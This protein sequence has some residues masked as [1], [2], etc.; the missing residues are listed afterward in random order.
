MSD[1]SQTL[2]G[3]I[4]PVVGM[5]APGTP[6]GGL[7]P[8]LVVAGKYRLVRYLARGGMAEVW[9]ATHEELRS[10]VAIKFVAPQSAHDPIEA[11][12]AL[13]RFRFEAQVSAKLAGH[14]RHVV[15]VHDAGVRGDLPYMV[16]E[17]VPGLTLEAEVTNHGRMDPLRLADVLDQ[18]AEALDAA[19]AIGIIHRDLKPSNVML[20]EQ[21]DGTTIAKVSDFGVAKALDSRVVLDRPRE[22][23]DGDLVGS[24]SFMSPE[25]IRGLDVD[26]A[27]DVWSLG[28]VAYE[29][30]TGERC[31]DGPTV[32]DVMVAVLTKP[33]T[34]A[35]TVRR[36]LPKSVDAWFERVLARNPAERFATPGEA[37]AAF[38]AALAGPAARRRV[39]VV[40]IGAALTGVAAILVLML[41]TAGSRSAST[42]PS[43]SADAATAAAPAQTAPAEAPAATAD[44]HPPTAD[45]AKPVARSQR[46]GRT[47]SAAGAQPAT[48]ATA[49]PAR[50]VE[51]AAPTPPPTASPP[52]KKRKIDPNE[53]Q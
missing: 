50:P 7:S 45:S 24:P 21:R 4:G 15:A 33:P 20:L 30:L 38:R 8:G 16:M 44:E 43:R 46:P 40:A 26:G 34:P 49:L 36:E 52:P 1:P 47:A 10:D 5:A 14:T 12:N 22:T 35:C 41:V 3:P 25:Q 28:V 39:G 9:L 29:T 11:P 23:A 13:A 17:Y 31:F 51:T 42:Q 18:V 27:T 37:A 32:S 48:T 6:D 53:I 2:S 19:H